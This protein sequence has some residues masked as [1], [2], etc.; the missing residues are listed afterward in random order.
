MSNIIAP[1]ND[2]KYRFPSLKPVIR[3]YV[4]CDDL[5]RYGIAYYD[6]CYHE[7]V[8]FAHPIDVGAEISSNGVRGA[9]ALPSN[10]VLMTD[11]VFHLR[12]DGT[13][14]GTWYDYTGLG[15][16]PA[17]DLRILM[18]VS[19]LGYC[20]PDS[21][22]AELL[23]GSDE[24]GYWDSYYAKKIGSKGGHANTDAQNKARAKNSKNAGRKKGSKNKPKGK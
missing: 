14:K 3:Q 12:D 13:Y 16:I 15:V 9:E 20:L 8:L 6:N 19:D 11:T 17:S 18:I 7:G 4:V 24:M 2:P 23:T 1:T 10:A 21:A 5:G 22:A